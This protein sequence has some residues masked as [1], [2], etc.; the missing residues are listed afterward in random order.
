MKLFSIFKNQKK[1]K[2]YALTTE[3]IYKGFDLD[4]PDLKENNLKKEK[5]KEIVDD[6]E[7]FIFTDNVAFNCKIDYEKI[8][9]NIELERMMDLYTKK[10]KLLKKNNLLLQGQ[11]DQIK[12]EFRNNN[13]EPKKK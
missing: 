4:F 9:K 8:K 10:L 12:K 6:D 7:E 3:E 11:Y 13:N 1:K 5:V 2:N